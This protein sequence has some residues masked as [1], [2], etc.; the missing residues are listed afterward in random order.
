MEARIKERIT[1]RIRAYPK[2]R[3]AGLFS[4]LELYG[5]GMMED[6]EMR[7]NANDNPQTN[8]S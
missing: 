7:K 1:E 6:A 4:A 3:H 2:E 5:E 8:P